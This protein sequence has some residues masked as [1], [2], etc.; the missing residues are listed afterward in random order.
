MSR[1]V[2]SRRVVSRHGRDVRGALR[3]GAEV[4]LC[5]GWECAAVRLRRRN[6]VCPPPHHDAGSRK[7]EAGG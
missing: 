3:Q 4:R 7:P 1:R 6:G 2:V 5:G